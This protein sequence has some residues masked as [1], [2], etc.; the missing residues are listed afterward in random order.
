MGIHGMIILLFVLLQF[1]V[2]VKDKVTVIDFTFTGNQASAADKQPSSRQTT[3]VQEPKREVRQQKVMTR[4]QNVSHPGPEKALSAELSRSD[5]LMPSR[6]KTI[7]ETAEQTSSPV[8]T[9]GVE[10]RQ[11]PEGP[12]MTA[13]AG[14]ARGGAD[15]AG[16]APSWSGRPDDSGAR[17]GPE[18]FRA[19]YL[20][21]HF[22]YIRDKITGSILYP[23]MARKMGWCGQVKIAFVVCEDGGVRDVRVVDSS[24]FRMLDRNAIDTVKNVA[25]FPKPPVKAEIR[26]AVLYRL[27]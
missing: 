10:D 11:T 17:S 16:A 24:G 2:V 12:S 5:N 20:K 27:N 21:E 13:I 25:P 18:Q 1:F 22:V 8:S 26:M 19:V 7:P 23:E 4:R 15:T 14:S 9:S 6:E 3:T